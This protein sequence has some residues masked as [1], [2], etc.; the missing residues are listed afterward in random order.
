MLITH[1]LC[2][3]LCVLCYICP[4]LSPRALS[5]LL[6]LYSLPAV[7]DSILRKNIKIHFGVDIE[8]TKRKLKGKTHFYLLKRKILLWFS[9]SFYFSV[10]HAWTVFR[11]NKMSTIF[12]IEKNIFFV[13]PVRST[14]GCEI[15]LFIAA[16]E[17]VKV[18]RSANTVTTNLTMEKN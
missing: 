9:F 14:V 4:G 15:W 18:Y 6:N 2:V 5:T 7:T 13:S 11:L 12:W 16:I 3:C 10:L 1:T 17:N 8:M